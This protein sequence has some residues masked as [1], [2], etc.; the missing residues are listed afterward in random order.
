MSLCLPS[1]H[2]CSSLP[3]LL[4]NMDG[5]PFL[6][7]LFQLPHHPPTTTY[8]LVLFQLY[9]FQL[10]YVTPT[11]ACSPV[12]SFLLNIPLSVTTPHSC[13]FL[14]MWS[15]FPSCSFFSYTSFSN[16]YLF[17]WYFLTVALSVTNHTSLIWSSFPTRSCNTSNYL[18]KW[19]FFVF[20][21]FA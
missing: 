21:F 6:L 7:F 10:Y 15:F 4:V 5:P 14:F 13:Y 18:F 2:H 19:S 1:S 17:T 9:L 8:S 11:T 12:P 3:L 20:F 16:Y